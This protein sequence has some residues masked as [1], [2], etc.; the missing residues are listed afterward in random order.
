MSEKHYWGKFKVING[1]SPKLIWVNRKM[2]RD[3]MIEFDDT[4]R[5]NSA[6][7]LAGDKLIYGIAEYL[8]LCR[9]ETQENA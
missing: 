2:T 1:E 5:H 8:E 9:K 3:E 7:T 4:L 6:E